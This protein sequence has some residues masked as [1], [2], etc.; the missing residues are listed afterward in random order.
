M[1]SI[2]KIGV[3][4]TP[5]IVVNPGSVPA[6]GVRSGQ[7]ASGGQGCVASRVTCGVG[8]TGG[9]VKWMSVPSNPTRD[10]HAGGQRKPTLLTLT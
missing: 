4:H 7:A 5:V 9:E 1:Q 3:I 2:L 6:G 8:G 10:N